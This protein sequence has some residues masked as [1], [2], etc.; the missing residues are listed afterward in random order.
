MAESVL[1][2]P[3]AR[4]DQ[5][6]PEVAFVLR[7][8]GERAGRDI[9]AHGLGFAPGR[10]LVSTNLAQAYRD[11][12]AV[13]SDQSAASVAA[14][15]EAGLVVALAVPPEFHLGY[16]AFSTAFVDRA[17]KTVFGSPLEYAGPRK[18]LAFYLDADTELARRGAE[19]E[20]GG[21]LD[22]Q[23]EGPSYVIDQRHVLGSFKAVPGLGHLMTE[24]EVSARA[25]EAVDMPGLEHS[26]T[27][28]FDCREPAQAIL[29][30]S[31][32]HRL[33]VGTI[34]SVIMSRLRLMRWQGLAML[35]YKFH[36]GGAD[37][38]VTRETD[39]DEQRRRITEC[40]Q[41]LDG[42]GVFAGELAWLKQY[43]HQELRLMRVE[44]DGEEL[45][46]A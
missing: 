38:A 1:E 31:M 27:E 33:V 41:Q 3:A 16:A 18:A 42:G 34:E 43:G 29:M 46:G 28:L 5:S 45:V 23:A 10:P 11:A 37:V 21:R 39:L 15:P 2:L 40:E 6:L 4:G 13:T 17:A 7:G 36:E 12:T 8:T 30:P 20:M 24:L 26:L 35:G 44:L 9:L 25:F 32:M 14:T 22:A 19:A